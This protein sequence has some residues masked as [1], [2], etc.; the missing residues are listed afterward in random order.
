MKIN[1]YFYI[2]VFLQVTRS[3]VLICCA[4]Q[5]KIAPPLPPPPPAN[6]TQEDESRA[7]CRPLKLDPSILEQQAKLTE[8]SQNRTNTDESKIVM[9]RE[10]IPGKLEFSVHF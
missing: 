5:P 6:S 9:G 7:S 3:E 8:E 4:I 1:S 10:A 2:V